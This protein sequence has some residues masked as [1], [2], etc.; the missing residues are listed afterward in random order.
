MPRPRTRQKREQRTDHEDRL[1]ALA[2]HQQERLGE[3]RGRRAAVGKDLLRPLEPG[4]ERGLDAGHIGTARSGA[5]AQVGEGGLEF[6]GES[7][8]L[9]ADGPLHLLERD[10][11]V[12]RAGLGVVQLSRRR[13]RHAGIDPV[14][15]FGKDQRCHL[16]VR[17]RGAGGANG[18]EPAQL[19]LCRRASHAEVGENAGIGAYRRGLEV[20]E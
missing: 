9:G 1:E 14:P 6:R 7:R 17:A 5:R 12:E 16:R 8:I 18:G 11:G 15:H 3:Q 13:E 4:V 2:Q 10:V 19:G 20:G